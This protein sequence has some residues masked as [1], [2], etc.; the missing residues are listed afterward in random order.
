MIISQYSCTYFSKAV[1]RM[2]TMSERP[3]YSAKLMASFN[4]VNP[5]GCDTIA[6]TLSL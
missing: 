5:L 4:P 6:L 3:L 2:L 1:L